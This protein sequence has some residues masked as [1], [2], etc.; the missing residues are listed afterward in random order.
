MVQ[1][2]SII[3]YY[4][5][6]YQISN[7]VNRLFTKTIFFSFGFFVD[8]SRW[9]KGWANSSKTSC[10]E[11]DFFRHCSVRSTHCMAK[12]TCLILMEDKK[13]SFTVKQWHPVAICSRPES[14]KSSVIGR[15]ILNDAEKQLPKAPSTMYGEVILDT[16]Y[17]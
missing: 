12:R 9:V 15:W 6:K 5:T 13:W 7:H 10:T 8:L 2:T 4:H 16:R 17:Q 3:F 11:Q 1:R 14:M